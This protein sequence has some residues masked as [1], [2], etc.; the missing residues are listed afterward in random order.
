MRGREKALVD[1]LLRLDSFKG[2]DD[3]PIRTALR[4]PDGGV[5]EMRVIRNEGIGTV[6]IPLRGMH[7]FRSAHLFGRLAEEQQRTGDAEPFHR[8]L[9][10]E[11]PGKCRST[12]RGMRV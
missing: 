11:Y 7:R 5:G 3:T 1:P 4:V 8:C 2:E 12:E 6:V 10:R 9:R